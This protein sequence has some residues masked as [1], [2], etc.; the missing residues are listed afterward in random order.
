MWPEFVWPLTIHCGDFYVG[1]SSWYRH[2]LRFP[3]ARLADF[4]DSRFAWL[5]SADA[6]VKNFFA[7]FDRST[8]VARRR[9]RRRHRRSEGVAHAASDFAF[10]DLK[11]E[12][13][14]DEDVE[15]GS[16]C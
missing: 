5:Q 3:N 2:H 9:E 4:L 7:T 6:A 13:R 10:V 11:E 15:C 16:R 14:D 12:P 8:L 1:G